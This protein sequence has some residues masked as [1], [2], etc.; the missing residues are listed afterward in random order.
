[1]RLAEGAGHQ[2]R[3]VAAHELPAGVAEKTARNGVGG[4]DG[5]E[6][7]RRAGDGDKACI[8]SKGHSPQHSV[9]YT[10]PRC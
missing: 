6:V 7:V 5:A 1:M 10:V 9:R 3:H 2:A 4:E 8:V